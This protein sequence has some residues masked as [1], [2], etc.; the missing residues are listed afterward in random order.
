MRHL[1]IH[2]HPSTVTSPA[3][4][5]RETARTG[6]RESSPLTIHTQDRT[7]LSGRRLGPAAAP[8]T[9]V[10]V[11][12]MLT[13]SSYWRPLT[14]YLD[15]RLDGGLAQL[16]YDQRGHGTTAPPGPRAGTGLPVLIDDLDTVL[17]HA[18][19]AVVLVAHSVASLLVQAWAGRYPRRARALA[20]I[21][22]F[23]G[24]HAFP[25]SSQPVLRETGRH[26][27]S[28][29]VE[30]LTTSLYPRSSRSPRR[31][32]RPNHSRGRMHDAD[33]DVVRAELAAYSSARLSGEIVSILRS[34]PTW[35]VTGELDLV[36]HPRMSQ[37]LAEL[38]WGDYSCVPD[39]GH[40]LPHLE[41]AAAAE[42]ILAA[43]EVA[44]RS[45]QLSGGAV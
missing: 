12:G 13:H 32:S 2:P 18:H 42:A 43:L 16:I 14:D 44:Y 35:I 45:R 34:V 33:A 25:W 5:T 17:A 9:V 20:G 39:A 37:E 23:N 36:V 27:E 30:E 31:R 41:P 11:H 21:V 3:A 19:G 15:Q 7:Q 6:H 1:W 26:W 10:Y 28:R 38:I 29:L 24:C 4:A 22:L 8:A 40:C